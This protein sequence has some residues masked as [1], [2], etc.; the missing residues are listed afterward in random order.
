MKLRIRSCQRLIYKIEI[1]I[2]IIFMLILSSLDVRCLFIMF[3]LRW[4][5]FL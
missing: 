3:F 5:V 4:D 2:I 1:I